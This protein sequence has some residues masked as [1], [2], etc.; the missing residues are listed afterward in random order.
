MCLSFGRVACALQFARCALYTAAKKKK[1]FKPVSDKR[2][3]WIRWAGRCG[4]TH[5]THVPDIPLDL[6]RRRLDRTLQIRSLVL[7]LAFEFVDFTLRLRRV[8][9]VV[10]TTGGEEGDGTEDEWG[11]YAKRS[12]RAVSNRQFISPSNERGRRKEWNSLLPP[13]GAGARGGGG[14]GG[15]IPA[16]GPGGGGG[17]TVASERC[18]HGS[19]KTGDQLA[20]LR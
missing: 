4:E 15:G 3:C 13:P 20:E 18:K 6:I 11:V 10:V 9:V 16:P 14:G 7:G 19:I 2:L 17:G 1:E 5:V 12:E 8:G